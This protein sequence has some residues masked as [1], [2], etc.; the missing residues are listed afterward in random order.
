M[1]KRRNCELCNEERRLVTKARATG[2][3]FYSLYGDIL[4]ELEK[5]RQT[6][7]DGIKDFFD[8]KCALDLDGTCHPYTSEHP[9]ITNE[10]SLLQ[11]SEVSVIPTW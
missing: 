6:A 1:R 8:F 5:P 2:S 9:A 7:G 11:S 10:F 3:S 4:Y